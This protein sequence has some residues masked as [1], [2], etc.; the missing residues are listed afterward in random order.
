MKNFKLALLALLFIAGFGNTYAQ[1]N[2]NPWALSFGTNAVDF[3]PTN[4]GLA[5]HGGWFD[6]FVNTGDHYNMLPVI[7]KISVGKYLADG[8]SLE[9][10]G[11]LNKISKIGDNTADDLSY[12]AFDGGVKYD[13]NNVFGESSWLDPY[14]TVGGG[15][16]WMDEL[17]TG[18]FNGGLGINFW[19]NNNLGL[20]LESKYKHTFESNIVQ[21]FQHSLGLVIKFGGTDTDGD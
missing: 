10:V 1:D 13:L 6:E 4:A 19:F 7:S 14:A 8:F 9:A 5:G 15:Y 3:Y 16:T 12:Y 11:S 2:N 18:T 21:H 20:N 17:G